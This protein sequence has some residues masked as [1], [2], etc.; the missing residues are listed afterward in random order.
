MSAP[1]LLRIKAL[2]EFQ[3]EEK[4][5]CRESRSLMPSVFL[6]HSFGGEVL[7]AD[8]L[9]AGPEHW[10]PLDIQG[11]FERSSKEVRSPEIFE[12]AKIVRSKHDR[13]G[14]VGF[15]FGAWGA[16]Q[17]GAKANNGLVDCISMAHPS[18]VTKEEIQGVGVPVQICAPEHDQL[19]TEEL[20][21]F[22]NRVIPTLGVP[23]DY[24]F[25][26][27]LTHGFSVRGDIRN[28][29]ERAGMERAKNAVVL[30]FRQ[31]LHNH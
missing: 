9:I 5:T 2:L 11:F 4:T 29:A 30:W 23:Y 15:C 20:K 3:N 21:E 27:G 28:K 31:W 10:G 25:F 1:I 18:Y 14:V 22:S 7:D 6:D 16:F 19:F 13:V 17:L 26:P 8:L 24:Q 12:C